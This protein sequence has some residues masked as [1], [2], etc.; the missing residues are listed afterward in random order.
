MGNISYLPGVFDKRVYT[1]PEAADVLGIKSTTMYKLIREG[2]IR[3]LKI[4]SLRRIP[5]EAIDEFIQE[6]LAKAS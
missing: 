4:G 1:V 3:S 5:A 6:M 2:Q